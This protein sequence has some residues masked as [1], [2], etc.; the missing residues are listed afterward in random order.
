MQSTGLER[1]YIVL[2]AEN[3]FHF[4]RLR[5]ENTRK[6]QHRLIIP[7]AR[8]ALS[9]PWERKSRPAFQVSVYMHARLFSYLSLQCARVG[10][11]VTNN[12]RGFI[13]NYVMIEV[14][15]QRLLASLTGLVDALFLSHYSL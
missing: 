8:G 6:Y 10:T 1:Q 14:V 9:S 11:F 3:S 12:G 2:S 13:S 15:A 7:R 4:P 5:N